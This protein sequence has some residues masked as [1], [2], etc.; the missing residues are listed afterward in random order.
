MR[1]T[2]KSIAF[3]IVHQGLGVIKMLDLFKFE[4]H[5]VRT[6][7][8]DSDTIWF[9]AKDVAE[10]LG[11]KN[12]N[13]AINRHCDGVAQSYPIIDNMGR[14]Q[15]V[16]IIN[17]PDMYALVFSSEL[18][19]AKVFKRWVFED[20][21]PK[22]RKHGEYTKSDMEAARQ[23]WD[24]E[25][26]QLELKNAKTTT[27]LIDSKLE[28]DRLELANRNITDLLD[29]TDVTKK[30]NDGDREG[31]IDETISGLFTGYVDLYSQLS[32]R[33]LERLNKQLD[34]SCVP[35]K[36]LYDLVKELPQFK[37]SRSKALFNRAL[38]NMIGVSLIALERGIIYV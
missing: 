11:Y 23:K 24:A 13:D 10:S 18:K 34:N 28:C 31:V 36:L 22:L 9:V 2:L 6:I 33:E 29:T 37:S 16:R 3:F 38:S 12:T 7:T 19:S 4:N 17:E 1:T 30:Y 14:T 20:V 26:R 15:E 25:K 27:Q 35:E 32:Q 8:D 5:E 21:L